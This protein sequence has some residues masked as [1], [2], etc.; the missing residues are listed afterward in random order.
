[1]GGSVPLRFPIQTIPKTRDDTSRPASGLREV[2][3]AEPSEFFIE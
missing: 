2:L 1:M 3:R